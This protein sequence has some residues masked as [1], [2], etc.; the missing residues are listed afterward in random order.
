M[1][2]FAKRSDKDRRDL[3]AAAA[4]KMGVHK[5]IIEK[6]FWVCWILDLLFH[7][8]PWKDQLSLK[9]GTSLSKV[10]GAIERFS[11]DIDLILN[12]ETLGYSPEDPF[13]DR[14]LTKQDAFGK[15][16]N[17][18]TVDFLAKEFIPGILP[19]LTEHGLDRITVYSQEQDDL[20]RYPKAFSL[21]AIQPEIR[22]EIGPV[23]AWIPNEMKSITPYAVDQFPQYFKKGSS[24]VRSILA[25]RTFWEKATILHQ[26]AHRETKK[27]LP[28]RYS[29][30]YYDLYRLSQS[31]IREK[32]LT[33]IDLLNDVVQFKM[34]FYRCNWANYEKAKP[35]SL[36]LLPPQHHADELKKDYKAMKSMLFGDIPE[37]DAIIEDLTNLE[38]TINTAG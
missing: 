24:T 7:E 2:D 25:E 30:H 5:A 12:W 36:K 23:A 13:K 31:P 35:G 1:R 20:I 17:Q 21:E 9:G 18:R 11:E 34:R 33:S 14:S 38:K 26:E 27:K 29:R 28:P 3:F 4:L 37:F 10:F 8:N 6:D 19:I 32:A 15:E 16:A 22:L